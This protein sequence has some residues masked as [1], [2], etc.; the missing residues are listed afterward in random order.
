M[1][2][3]QKPILVWDFLKMRKVKIKV[4]LSQKIRIIDYQ[5]W[6]VLQFYIF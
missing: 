6:Q 1:L 4:E 2:Y 3:K 5:L